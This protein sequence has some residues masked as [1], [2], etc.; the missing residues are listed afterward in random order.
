[1][2][3]LVASEVGAALESA[4]C[5]HARVEMLLLCSDSLRAD[6]R[7][8]FEWILRS[9]SASPQI[10]FPIACEVIGVGAVQRAFNEAPLRK[11][12]PTE[13]PR[14]AAFI[15][16]QI[17]GDSLAAFFLEKPAVDAPAADSSFSFR[18]FIPFISFTPSCV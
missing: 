7:L 8:F 14:V 13:V 6:Y 12:P 10:P 9:T 11:E 1:M 2:T 18:L 3:G 15:N 5:F 4:K 16:S 17:S